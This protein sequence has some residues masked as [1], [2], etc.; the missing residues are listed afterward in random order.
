MNP[1]N[2]RRRY[3]VTSSPIGWAHTQNEPCITVQTVGLIPDDIM[4]WKHIPH[5]WP[6]VRGIHQ[7]PMISPDKGLIIQCLFQP[8]QTVEPTAKLLVI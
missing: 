6:F 2:E 4:T 5:Y 8:E 3:N 7:S 1:A